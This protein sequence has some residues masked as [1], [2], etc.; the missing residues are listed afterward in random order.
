MATKQAP[1]CDTKLCQEEAV[2]FDKH[3]ILFEDSIDPQRFADY[4]TSAEIGVD[5]Y[6]ELSAYP[7]RR[8]KA[9]WILT[10]YKKEAPSLRVLITYLEK[11]CPFA[12][13][14]IF[15]AGKGK[16]EHSLSKPT[17]M[18][19]KSVPAKKILEKVSAD[20]STPENPVEA[21]TSLPSMCGAKPLYKDNSVVR[22][23]FTNAIRRNYIE[24]IYYVKQ[25]VDNETFTSLLVEKNIF[26]QRSEIMEKL[27]MTT[28]TKTQKAKDFS[29]MMFL[30]CMSDWVHFLDICKELKSPMADFLEYIAKRSHI[31]LRSYS[32]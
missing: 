7:T 6:E 11:E 16:S 28:L 12:Y 20:Q 31:D 18:L 15:K 8:K 5:L 10:Q 2:F 4:M 27:E 14:K 3:W 21:K 17:E 24:F 29:R 23:V 32:L 19:K 13:D 26:S 22:N 30:R 1:K 9:A 25:L